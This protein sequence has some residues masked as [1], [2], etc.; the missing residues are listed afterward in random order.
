MH[1]RVS[2]QRFGQFS[3]TIRGKAIR[4]NQD[5]VMKKP[6]VVE[7]ERK[8]DEVVPVPCYQTAL[9]QSSPL[10]LFEIRKSFSP[11]LVSTK[12]INSPATEQFGNP[13]A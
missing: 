12:S 2:S 13:L 4:H 5:A 6:I 9:L 3:E 1:A 7:L 8:T 11:D 10:K